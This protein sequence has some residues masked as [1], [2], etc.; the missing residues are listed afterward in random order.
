MTTQTITQQIEER[1]RRGAALLAA[2]PRNVAQVSVTRDH[3]LYLVRGSESPDYKVVFA[4]KPSCECKDFARNSG[5][6]G[7]CK[8]LEA[9]KLFNRVYALIEQWGDDMATVQAMT[10]ATVGSEI[11][12]I[13]WEA[14]LSVLRYRAGIHTPA[15]VLSFP[16]APRVAVQAVAA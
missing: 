2:D 4:E 5:K 10:G 8:H 3:S 15:A 16:I 14:V 13:R 6:Y 1:K 11:N 7:T 12:R 9:V